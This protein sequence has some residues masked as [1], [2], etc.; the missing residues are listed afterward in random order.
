MPVTHFSVLPSDKHGDSYFF[1]LANSFDSENQ[2]EI[3]ISI[4]IED[5]ILVRDL[6]LKKEGYEAGSAAMEALLIFDDGRHQLKDCTLIE[7]TPFVLQNL[8]NKAP[9]S[10]QPKLL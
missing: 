8:L 5:P 7:R 10:T 9:F 4:D 1:G 2:F 6:Y 3:K